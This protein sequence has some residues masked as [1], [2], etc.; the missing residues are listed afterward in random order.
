MT[1]ILGFCGYADPQ[2]AERTLTAMLAALHEDAPCYIDQYVAAPCGLARM[3]LGHIDQEPQPLWS[4]DGNVAL[5]MVGEIFSWDGLEAAAAH[6]APPA[7][8]SKD[9]GAQTFSNARLLLAAYAQ[10]G[11]EFVKH[12]NGS[13]AAAIWHVR[14]QK[15]LL[16]TDQIGTHPVYYAQI[17]DCLVFGSGARAVAQAP[18]LPRAVEVAAVAEL[19][20]F[21]QV[22]G[23]KTLFAGVRLLPA[24]ALT[25]FQAG[26][27]CTTRYVDYQHPEYYQPQSE[28]EIVEQWAWYMRQAVAR[29]TRGPAPLGVLLTGGFDSRSI[30]ALM[31]RQ[32]IEIVSLTFGIAGCDDVRIARE[33]AHTLGVQHHYF[34]LPPDFL[35][36]QAALG[37][38]LT[39]GMKS[40]IHMNMLGTLTQ[41][42]QQAPVLY[43]GYLGGTIHGHVVTAD[44]L[45]PM[46]AEDWFGLVYARR[47]DLFPE[48][49][50]AQ[51]YTAPMLGRV[52]HLPQGALRDELA[53]SHATW[54]VD[55]ESY[56]DLYQYDRR[57]TSMGVVLARSQ[58]LVRLPL[59]DKDMLHFAVSVPPGYRLDRHYYKL[60][61]A[62]AFPALAKIPTTRTV[63]PLAS[64]L[65]ELGLRASDQ[66]RWWLRGHGLSL[67]PMRRPQPY[68]DY[69]AWLRQGLRPWVEQVLLSPQSF[70]RDYFDPAYLRGLVAAHMAGED[71]T[72]RLGVLLA[73]EL[74]HQQYI[75]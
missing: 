33:V 31:D 3:H 42:V 38:R 71:H 62:R 2:A 59:A 10:Y 26:V 7:K 58:A 18:G 69:A 6:L 9:V 24:G 61:L 30:L 27:L 4:D 34:P 68:A 21:E 8:D 22:F 47:N 50:W 53:Q 60:A 16:V 52:Q 36:R 56:V 37:V 40:V 11:E 51:L 19:I 12:V 41:L 29:Q 63:Y 45:A 13:F 44:R 67:V 15:L 20:A 48:R 73:L 35:I 39:D 72:R 43:K 5:V 46:R 64:S 55:K 65:R 54:W 75:D 74:W 17:G 23:D 28:D 1:A 70:G 14:E 66:V 57:F 32:A 49:E 25:S